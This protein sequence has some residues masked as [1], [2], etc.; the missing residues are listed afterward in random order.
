MTDETKKQASGEAMRG[1]RDDSVS[2][3][4]TVESGPGLPGTPAAEVSAASRPAAKRRRSGRKHSPSPAASGRRQVEMAAASGRRRLRWPVIE[5]VLVLLLVKIGAGAWMLLSGPE[6]A[7]EMV[8]APVVPLEAVAPAPEAAGA[9][10][11]TAGEL[12]EM[13]RKKAEARLAAQLSSSSAGSAAGDKGLLDKLVSPSVAQ[14]SSPALAAAAAPF[15]SGALFVV[16]GQSASSSMPRGGEN[17]TIPLPPGADLLSPAAELPPPSLPTLGSGVT[18]SR[19]AGNSRDVA[20]LPPGPASAGGPSADALRAREQALA[21]KEAELAS[22]EEAL[23]AL[24]ADIR[25]QMA[26]IDNFRNE[27]ESMI[28]RNEAVLAEMKALREEQRK[29]DEI[30]RDAAIQQLVAAYGAMKPEQAGALVNSLDDDVAVS[31]LSIMTGRKAGM[32]LANVV[33]EKAARLTKAISERRID[34]SL[35]LSDNPTGAGLPANM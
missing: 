33:P 21:V 24:D 29:E 3:G 17:E 16:T 6:A 11:I 20:P 31:I 5:A 14:A 12:A 9:G 25:R 10:L 35:I 30:R 34:P 27:Q 7:R 18:S 22:R 28:S 4:L 32:I 13:N 2:A 1:G 23:R 19:P 26:A 15:A 8:Q